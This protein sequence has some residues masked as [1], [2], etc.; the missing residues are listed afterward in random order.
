MY[1]ETK[2]L[3]NKFFYNEHHLNHVELLYFLTK[4]IPSN[5]LN[6]R[7][8]RSGNHE[9]IIQTNWQHWAHNIQDEDEQRKE[10]QHK[11]LKL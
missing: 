3:N 5:W 9:W 11:K 8:N 1:K 7:E 6:I 10:T 2:L 4:F